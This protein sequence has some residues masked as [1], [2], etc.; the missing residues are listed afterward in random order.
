MAVKQV[1]L[2]NLSSTQFSQE[3]KIKAMEQEIELLRTL[4]H[5]NIVKYLGTKKDR[6]KFSI[7]LEYVPG[8]SLERIY[9]TYPMNENLIQI[10]T[11]QIL[12]GIEYLHA[13]NVIHRDIKAANILID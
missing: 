4:N 2:M 9:K 11:K 3:K 10:Y 8:G 7:F 1:P 6:T 5:K 13:H 12:E